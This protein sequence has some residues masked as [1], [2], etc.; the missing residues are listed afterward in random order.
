MKSIKAK[1]IISLLPEVKI[2]FAK[3]QKVAADGV[4]AEVMNAEEKVVSLSAEMAVLMGKRIGFVV[5]K[6]DV[7]G[8][9]GFLFKKKIFCPVEGEIIKVDEYN[10]VYLRATEQTREEIISPVEAVVAEVDKENLT[11]EFRAV[12]FVGMSLSEGRSWAK[13]G[14][15]VVED[16][17]DLSVADRAKI[18]V[19]ADLSPLIAAKAEVVG[20]AG[21]VVKNGDRINT[22]LPI[23]K[24]DPEEYQN[25]LN[26][27]KKAKRAMLDASGGRLLLVI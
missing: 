7:L 13:N 18:I 10:N 2:L 1:W 11:I 8:E 22:K 3:G 15:K 6:G 21:M 23:V 4:L 17:G 19:L 24:V 5:K 16:V 20:V 26:E 14:V 25:I 27:Y 12:E 9:K